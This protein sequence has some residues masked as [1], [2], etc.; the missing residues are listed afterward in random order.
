MPKIAYPFM[1]IIAFLLI[2]FAASAGSVINLSDFQT[3]GF[4][5]TQLTGFLALSMMAIALLL[6]MRLR[7]L[8]P[9]FGGLDKM[10]RL[11]KWLAIG[12]IPFA[13]AHWL[14]KTGGGHHG[15]ETTTAADAVNKVAS[16]PHQFDPAQ[17]ATESLFPN[18]IGAAHGIAQPVLFLLF[19][20]LAMAL[21]KRIPY[22]LFKKLHFVMAIIFIV[23]ALHSLILM[24]PEYWTTPFGW[25]T[26]AFSVLGSLASIYLLIVRVKGFPTKQA[27]VSSTN[28]FPE[29][30]VLEVNLDINNDWN[31]H[32]A[33]QFVFVETDR[34]EGAH[35][36]TLSTA[37]PSRTGEIGIIAK[38][39]GDF[40]AQ[41]KEK[42]QPG[43]KVKING[44]YG[45]FTFKSKKPRQIWIGAGIGIT[46]FIAQ[47][48]NLAENPNE[49]TIDLFHTTREVSEIALERMETEAKAAGVTLHITQ[50]TRDGRLTAQK[51][52]EAVPD[53]K[54][55]S[56][57]FCGPVKFAEELRKEFKQAG[58]KDKDFHQELF[59]MR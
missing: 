56:I 22:R 37:W 45:R 30:K 13:L 10:Y 23:F 26:I 2:V 59:E 24:R 53:W 52:M 48:R 9:I 34:M 5:F 54:Q 41:M 6:A 32:K 19:A 12:A 1:A 36:F 51:L 14:I 50:T 17:A 8:E 57:W 38:E 25:S 39:L 15:E 29:L 18:F 44:P 49:K 58:L 28:Y 20:L 55:A 43:T 47:M 7:W 27:T 21:I 35:P 33:G 42:F 31:G 46:P 11:H 3:V 4:A 40:T 16:A